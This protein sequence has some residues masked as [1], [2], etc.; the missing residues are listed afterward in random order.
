MDLTRY[1]LRLG[2]RSPRLFSLPDR[3][4]L[5]APE[6]MTAALLSRSTSGLNELSGHDESTLNLFL[7]L[8]SENELTGY[9][10]E[11][12]YLLKLEAKFKSLTINH[13]GTKTD[14][15]TLITRQSGLEAIK[16]EKFEKKFAAFLEL[17]APLNHELVWL[18][19]IVTSRTAYSNAEYRL[20]GDFD[21]YV[22]PKHFPQLLQILN[23]NEFRVIAGDTGFC[24][25]LG[26]GPV[27]SIVDLF[28]VPSE[29]L[30][31][32]AVCG[33]YRNRWPLLDIKV[34][35]LD[36]GLKMVE[37]DRFE[38][39]KVTVSWQRC[40]FTAPD[41][42]DQLLIALTHFEKDR[43]AGWKQILDIKLLAEKVN[44]TPE[45]WGEFVRRARV[46]GVGTACSAGLSLARERLNL[47]GVDSVIEDLTPADEKMSRRWLM[48]TVTPLFY[49]NTS[50]LPML[51]A[52]AKLADDSQRKLRV[53][54]ES[55]RPS[56]QFLSNYYLGGR[57]VTFFSY[58]YAMLLHWLVLWLPGGVVR[59]T[60]GKLIWRENQFGTSI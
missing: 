36:R 60:F 15:L 39:N 45:F 3:H 41:L 57:P 46:E 23:A 53:I 11:S 26:V 12:I 30:I 9:C 22:N 29:D 19:G 10:L 5:S 48:F 51:Y 32:S 6:A 20:S 40:I 58:M 42:L 56:K 13:H 7:D 33:M 25:Q 50:S 8:V 21:C 49:W 17:T 47:A 54:Q 24:N 31:P 52:N 55:L 1:K 4:H 2:G 18:K 34:N 14:L 16:F 38:R 43:F 28:L 59:R 44:Q 35:P 27:S 37:L